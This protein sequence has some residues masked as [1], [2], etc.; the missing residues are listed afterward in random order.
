MHRSPEQHPVLR[1]DEQQQQYSSQ[2]HSKP[3]AVP[4]HHRQT[5]PELS[6]NTFDANDYSRSPDYAEDQPLSTP[7]SPPPNFNREP[8][9][10]AQSPVIP[11]KSSKRSLRSVQSPI[12][13]SSAQ[14]HRPHR[15]LAAS[16]SDQQLGT[17]RFVPASTTTH[18]RI[19]SDSS[20]SDSPRSIRLKVSSFSSAR[21]PAAYDERARQPRLTSTD[22]ADDDTRWAANDLPVQTL[23]DNFPPIEMSNKENY[24]P[25]SDGQNDPFARFDSHPRTP[26]R[27][28]TPPPSQGHQIRDSHD[29]SLSPRNVTRDS[30]LGNMLLSLDQFSMGQVNSSQSNGGETRAMSGFAESSRSY[31]YNE[32][33][34]PRGGGGGAASKTMTNSTTRTTRAGSGGRTHGYS[35]SSDYETSEEMKRGPRNNSNNNNINNHGAHGRRSNSSSTVGFQSNLGRID[36]MRDRPNQRPTPGT[37]KGQRALH[38][39]GERG[40]KSSSTSSIDTGGYAS[41]LGS[42]RWAHG[43]GVPKR[44]SSVELAHR[45][46]SFGTQHPAEQH[47]RSPRRQQHQQKQQSSNKTP[48]HIDFANSLFHP[49]DPHQQVNNINNND[50]DNDYDDAAPTPTVPAGPSRQLLTMPSMP[51]FGRTAPMGE[52]LSPVR[53]ANLNPLERKRSNKSTR[54]TA[55]RQSPRS[56]RSKVRGGDRDADRPPPLPV[57]GSYPVADTADLPDS[58]PAPHVGYEKAK[59]KDTVHAT[60]PQP[61]TSQTK[62]KQGFFRRMFG[63]GTKNNTSEQSTAAATSVTSADS[64]SNSPTLMANTFNSSSS[65][66]VSATRFPPNASSPLQPTVTRPADSPSRQTS[67]AH[68]LQKKPSGFFRR[69]KKSMSVA[70]EPLPMP[71]VLPLPELL[72]QTKR[73]ELLTPR[74]A[75]SSMTSLRKAMDPYLHSSQSAQSSPVVAS[76]QDN[77]TLSSYHSAVEEINQPGDGNP[78]SFSP[79]YEPDPRATIR[80]VRSQQQVGKDKSTALEIRRPGTPTRDVSKPPLTYE[81]TS[82]FLH[83]NSDSE[84]SPQWLR[85]KAEQQNADFGRAATP[86]ISARGTLAPIQTDLLISS[87]SSNTTIKDKKL[88]RMT[89]DSMSTNTTD[90]PGSLT[91]PIEGARTDPNLKTQVS[92]ASIPSLLVEDSE[93][94]IPLAPSA[95]PLDEPTFVIGEPTEDDKAKAQKIFDGNED[96]IPKEKAASWMGEEGPIRQRT[97]RAYMDLFDFSNKSVVTSLRDVCNRLVLRAETQ[98]VDRILVTFSQRWVD[99]NPNHGFKSTGKSCHPMQR[100]NSSILTVM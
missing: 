39:R 10:A 45:K 52:P 24:S 77:L 63:G 85:K 58:A 12:T 18:L 55:T 42:Q 72:P 82:S 33:G 47:P 15:G 59:D 80:S 28:R 23:F 76:P 98:Q 100:W 61:A 32:S 83:D 70:S 51:S 68:G 92:A 4:Q 14:Q 89:Q 6:I 94:K 96:F 20:A 81:R 40:S 67:S 48:W 43:A 46:G 30:L 22:Y 78:R 54:S 65:T 3:R 71:P 95:H 44:S 19:D 5:K 31:Y 75:P 49:S 62:E 2:S 16:R 66:A 21:A 84:G 91:L 74:A 50:D 8:Y 86:D 73:L 56:T 99:C 90:R 64:L 37:T 26:T 7:L 27:A 34:T 53:S 29:L 13:P 9:A 11:F 41:V 88:N 38:S 57:P 35:Y 60:V 36:S 97:L 1:R 79:D 17:S 69:R 25:S 87:P 93:A